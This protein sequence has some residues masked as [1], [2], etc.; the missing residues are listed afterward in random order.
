M[1]TISSWV[2]HATREP[3]AALLTGMDQWWHNVPIGNDP[4][5]ACPWL[6]SS[7]HRLLLVHLDRAAH[8]RRHVP[9]YVCGADCSLTDHGPSPIATLLRD[10]A[11]D[12]A[13]IGVRHTLTRTALGDAIEAASGNDGVLSVAVVPESE[14]EDANDFDLHRSSLISPLT[15]GVAVPVIHVAATAKESLDDEVEREDFL[16]AAGWATYLVDL[17]HGEEPLTMHA[18]LA[19]AI[20]D[21]FDEISQIKADAAAR[22][23]MNAP[24]WPALVVRTTPQWRTEHSVGDG[25]VGPRPPL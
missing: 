2:A 5:R 14:F 25:S 12:P 21:V 4:L 13:P 8:K 6:S 7:L 1:P 16:R 18:R 22:V 20:E 3:G 9:L 17:K 11:Y 23:L 19:S 24:L 15:D 10:D